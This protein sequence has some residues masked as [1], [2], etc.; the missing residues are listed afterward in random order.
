M[1]RLTA[2]YQLTIPRAVAQ[3]VGLKPGD[4]VSWEAVGDAIRLRAAAAAAAAKHGSR[5]VTDQLILFDLATERE[6]YRARNRAA[7]PAR[8]RGWSREELYET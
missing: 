5:S 6:Q 8:D 7:V 4:E 1:S 3:S 2:K